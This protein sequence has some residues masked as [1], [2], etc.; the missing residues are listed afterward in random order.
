MS[1]GRY[2]CRDHVSRG[3]YTCRD[4]VS[5]PFGDGVVEDQAGW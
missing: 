5:R 2:N 4:H 3:W 1:R